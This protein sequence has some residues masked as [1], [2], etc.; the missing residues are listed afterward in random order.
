MRRDDAPDEGTWIDH[1]SGNQPRGTREGRRS[2]TECRR[3]SSWHCRLTRGPRRTGGPSSTVGVAE[4]LVTVYFPSGGEG[5][6]LRVKPTASSHRGRRSTLRSARSH[7]G[8]HAG[9]PRGGRRVL[10]AVLAVVLAVGLSW[11]GLRVFLPGGNPAPAASTTNPAATADVGFRTIVAIGD[12]GAMHVIETITFDAPR[13]RL[14]LSVPLRE[15]AGK[16][17]RPTVSSLVVREPSPASEIDPMSVGDE[18]SVR[19]SAPAGRVVLEYD[20]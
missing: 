5:K 3:P 11:L 9:R 8:A 6:G 15:G 1:I 10:L 7:A 17:F 13:S 12:A 4:A 20:A 2:R 18:T 14:R 19:F 16:E